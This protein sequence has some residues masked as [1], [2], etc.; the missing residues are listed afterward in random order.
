[1]RSNYAILMLVLAGLILLA[2]LAATPVLAVPSVWGGIGAGAVVVISM[3][4]WG[5]AFVGVVLIEAAIFSRMLKLPVARAFWVVIVL[6]V[7]SALLGALVG[8]LAFSAPL[9]IFAMFI[10]LAILGVWI[11]YTKVIPVW[12]SVTIW[13]TMLMGWTAAYVDTMVYLP[14]PGIATRYAGYLTPL[15]LGFGL[16][17]LL[18]GIFAKPLLKRDRPWKTLL[19]AN[20]A[21]YVLLG[22]VLLF[23]SPPKVGLGLGMKLRAGSRAISALRD[24]GSAQL[25]YQRQNNWKAY[26]SLEALQDT[27]HISED[28]TLEN[29]I[30]HYNLHWE[31]W[32]PTETRSL[33]PNAPVNGVFNSFT[34]IAWPD[35]TWP[36]LL[37][38]FAITEDQKIRVYT[39]SEGDKLDAVHTWEPLY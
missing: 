33:P 19:I 27:G 28:A 1:M 30:P 21:S 37:C 17:L 22:I 5:L 7:A 4:T 29:L 32:P 38:T 24:V 8:V 34:V 36:G 18:K 23:C 20:I 2:L 3:R 31:T 14:D 9:D 39:P 25:A 15:L 26:G 35:D 12:A 6:N 10:Y 11:Q 13:V 16:T